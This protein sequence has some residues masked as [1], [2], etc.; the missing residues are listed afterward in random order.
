MDDRRFDALTRALSSRRTALGSVAGTLAALLGLALPEEAE[1]HNFLARCRRIKDPQRR[2]ACLRRARAHNRRHR[3]SP[4]PP[5]PPT[6]DQCQGRNVCAQGNAATCGAAGNECYCWVTPQGVSVCGGNDEAVVA[7][8][9]ADCAAAGRICVLGDGLNCPGPFICVLPCCPAGFRE[10][11]GRCVDVLRDPNNC[12]AC[13]RSCGIDRPNICAGGSC[14]I[15][16]G[17]TSP[18]RCSPSGGACAPVG[19]AC[20]A[21]GGTCTNGVCP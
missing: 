13:G 6:P 7:D 20:C 17:G 4:P 15:D 8:R 19:E 9:C 16:A 2:R 1:S 12:G 14:C 11:N 10:C 3:L 18:C 21:G 5:P